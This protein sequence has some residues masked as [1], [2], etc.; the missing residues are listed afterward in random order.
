LLLSH[1]QA[2]VVNIAAFAA[3]HPQPASS[4][5]TIPGETPYD[6]GPYDV[7]ATAG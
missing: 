7:V 4:L 3:A 5:G 6:S 2:R 1:G